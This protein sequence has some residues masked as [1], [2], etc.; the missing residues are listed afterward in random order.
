MSPKSWLDGGCGEPLRLAC[1]SPCGVTV[2]S[3]DRGGGIG[4]RNVAVLHSIHRRL[5]VT[6]VCTRGPEEAVAME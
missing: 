5:R 1:R 3:G 6:A 4:S 2:C